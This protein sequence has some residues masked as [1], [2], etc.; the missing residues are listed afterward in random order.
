M[1]SARRTTNGNGQLAA[2]KRLRA[3]KAFL[4]RNSSS[5]TMTLA[6]SNRL[7]GR[8]RTRTGR[9]HTSPVARWLIQGHCSCF[10]S[11]KPAEQNYSHI[12]KEGLA[13]IFAVKKFH[14]YIYGWH[15]TLLTDHWPILSIFGNRKGIPFHSAS[16]LQRW[17]ATL[18]G[19]DFRI[20]VWLTH[21]LVLF[22]RTRHRTKKSSSLLNKPSSTW[23]CWPVTFRWPSTNSARL[24]RTMYCYKQ[25]RNSS[26][27]TDQTSDFSAISMG[28]TNVESPSRSSKV[29]LCSGNVWLFRPHCGPKYSISFAKDIRRSN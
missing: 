22:R 3:L 5:L 4:I 15:F 1:T 7:C 26:T 17:A 28:S 18:L 23:T 12:E 8:V 6:W 9:R 19:Y 13:L 27:L 25:W 29:L 16:R 20:L 21:S 2:N 11:L 10:F 24:P 14:T